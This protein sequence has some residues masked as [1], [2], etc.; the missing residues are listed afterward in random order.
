[1]ESANQSRKK[2]AKRTRNMSTLEGLHC[3]ARRLMVDKHKVGE[4]HTESVVSYGSTDTSTIMATTN[5][6]HTV[7]HSINMVSAT[8]SPM[9]DP[10]QPDESDDSN[11]AAT[12]S[13]T[14]IDAEKFISPAN[15]ATQ[16]SSST[17]YH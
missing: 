1:M 4:S 6:Q 3:D 9:E 8:A 5:N 17:A 12:Q 10:E 15:K 14:L 2:T 13:S 11:N 7:I 16:D